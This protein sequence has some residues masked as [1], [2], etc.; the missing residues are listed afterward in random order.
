MKK[1][2]KMFVVVVLMV[3]MITNSYCS[4]LKLNE[5]GFYLTNDSPYIFRGLTEQ[6]LDENDL[7]IK[8][9]IETYIDIFSDTSKAKLKEFLESEDE[10]KVD[11]MIRYLGIDFNENALK[12]ARKMQGY[13]FN[14]N[15]LKRDLKE[16]G[17]TSIEI[18]YAIEK[19]IL[20][21]NANDVNNA[22]HDNNM[23]IANSSGV[24]DQTVDPSIVSDKVK[25]II[26]TIQAINFFIPLSRKVTKDS[27]KFDYKKA[28]L[29]RA[30]DECKVDWQKNCNY[31]YD[32][33]IKEIESKGITDIYKRQK[34]LNK[35]LSFLG[36]TSDEIFKAHSDATTKFQINVR[37]YEN[38]NDS[39]I[40]A[41]LKMNNIPDNQ[42]NQC[43]AFIK[44][45]SAALYEAELQVDD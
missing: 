28:D 19:I 8:E 21:N 18:N 27:L 29:E 44:G 26:E 13:N 2:L 15:E 43:I 25:N 4:E 42:I 31:Y 16:A 32:I 20:D 30:L 45:N 22:N 35:K 23:N 17:F 1:F 11:K 14:I 34:Y 24:T 6:D 37:D 3:C 41:K 12:Y 9:K 5:Q 10:E 36:F 7:Q 33:Y 38:L 40:I 39:E